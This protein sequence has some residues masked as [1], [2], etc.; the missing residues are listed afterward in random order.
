MVLA[1][2][3]LARR[4]LSVVSLFLRIRTF[5]A[6]VGIV[7]VVWV[8]GKVEQ[9]GGQGGGGGSGADLLT[10]RVDLGEDPR[11]SEPLK[12]HPEKS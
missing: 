2:M 11:D 6:P 10:G 12:A 7:V 8:V 1:Q 5:P 4:L 3:L 9:G